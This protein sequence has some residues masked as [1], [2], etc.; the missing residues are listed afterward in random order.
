MSSALEAAKPVVKRCR[1]CLRG[2]LVAE[3]EKLS[4]ELAE[5]ELFD[6]NENRLPEAPPIAARIVE[7]TD[8]ARAAETEF[9][10]QAL[11]RR[12]WR[13]L[14]AQHPPKDSDKEAGRDFDGETFPAA[15]MAA[16]CT[17]PTG[18]TLAQ[19]EQLRDGDSIG[20]AQW[21]RLWA[22]CNRANT[23]GS[24][25]PLSEAAFALARGTEQKPAAQ[26]T[27]ASPEASS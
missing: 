13:D 18:A 14:V 11:G 2:D 8:Q 12:A 25:I 1:V 17:S 21:N 20:D 15:A 23:G 16:C 24:D 4:Y 9:V 6:A 19:F 27:T 7:L 10:F 5:A 22:T 3:I 26:G